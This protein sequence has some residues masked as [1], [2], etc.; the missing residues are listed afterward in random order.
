MERN[1][2]EKGHFIAPKVP[3][4]VPELTKEQLEKLQSADAEIRA[5][6]LVSIYGDSLPQVP[7][8]YSFV[9]RDRAFV[10]N[11]FNAAFDLIGGVPRF[12]HWAH[13]NPSDFYKLYAKMGAE[14]DKSNQALGG[15]QINITNHIG[16]SPLDDATYV[17]A[18]IVDKDEDRDE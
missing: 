11:A 1:K 13:Q 14:V 15:A 6:G 3:L 8:D 9:L 7:K 10:M 17:E 4:K 5:S 16:R 18:H 12:V 2:N